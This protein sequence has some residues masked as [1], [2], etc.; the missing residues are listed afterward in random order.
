M[1]RV[2]IL[3]AGLMPCLLIGQATLTVDRPTLR[4][5]DHFSAR[6]SVVVPPG[7]QWIN[8]Q[9]VWPD[10]L[11]S[12]E[13]VS[14]PEQTGEADLLR[15]SYHLAVFDTGQVMLPPLA[16]ILFSGDRYDTLYTASVTLTVESVEPDAEGLNPIRDIYREPFRP[17]YYLR[18][19][20]FAIAAIALAIGIWYYLRRRRLVAEPR[21]ASAPPLSPEAWAEAR[22]AEL[23][24]DQLWHK[25]EIK[26]HYSRLTA[27]FRE[28]LERRY[29]IRA[30]EQT[31][32]EIVQQLRH[33]GLPPDVVDDAGQLLQIADLVKFAKGDPGMDVHAQALHRVRTYVRHAHPSDMDHPS[34]DAEDA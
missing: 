5:G 13:V 12:V 23:E 14:G 19:L 24:A 27:I 31:T 32:P 15:D 30:L 6:V 29:A 25:G 26:T 22:L 8:R 3:L 10:S 20:P 33:S 16:V 18:Y 9:Q 17:A 1:R 21:P 4:L 11:Q 34:T 7:S 28:Y 2:F